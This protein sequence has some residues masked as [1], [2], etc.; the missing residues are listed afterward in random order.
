MNRVGKF[1]AA[2]VACL[3]LAMASFASFAASEFEGTWA[4]KD[5]GGKP[6]EITLAAGGAATATM[7]EAATG[8]WK[9]EG[10]SA[11]ITWK[12]GWVTKISKGGDSYKKSAEKDGKPVGSPSNIEKV[13]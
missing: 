7:P 9:E 4:V 10:S 1:A 2:L 8:T 12:S 5:S 3:V 13:E 6:F 11:V